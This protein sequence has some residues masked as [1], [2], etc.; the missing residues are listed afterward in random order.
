MGQ[1]RRDVRRILPPCHLR[2]RGKVEDGSPFHVDRAPELSGN[3]LTEA[4]LP[5][6][7]VSVPVLMVIVPAKAF[8][9]LSINALVPCLMIAPLPVP[10]NVPPKVW[11]VLSDNVRVLP[12]TSTLPPEKPPPLRLPMVSLALS[13]SVAPGAFART[14]ARRPRWRSLH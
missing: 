2:R 14:T 5:K 3:A 6:A 8:E 7:K 4:L 1:L 9:L 12:W 11:L 10:T 13:R